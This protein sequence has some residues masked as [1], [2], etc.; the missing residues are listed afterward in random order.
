M[1]FQMSCRKTNTLMHF[2][3]SPNIS[4]AMTLKMSP[5]FAKR[6]LQLKHSLF[7][8]HIQVVVQLLEWMLMPKLVI[9]R[10]KIKT[11]V[12]TYPYYCREFMKDNWCFYE[13]MYIAAR[14]KKIQFKNVFN[15]LRKDFFNKDTI[16]TALGYF[17][18][19]MIPF[20]KYE[21]SGSFNLT[22]SLQVSSTIRNI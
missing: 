3:Y 19:V 2:S 21:F 12:D 22:K 1:R 9:A 15:F 11:N 8:D 4:T 17:A 20:A 18:D 7:H 6:T 14:N 13:Q 16:L 5:K 10:K